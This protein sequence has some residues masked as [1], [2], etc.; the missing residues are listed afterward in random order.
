[1]GSPVQNVVQWRLVLQGGC[2]CEGWEYEEGI[3]ACV[4]A[5]TAQ[6]AQIHNMLPEDL[7]LVQ[8]ILY[9]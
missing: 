2:H 4:Q 8:K 1:M 5:L 7:V 3:S 6:T 9:F